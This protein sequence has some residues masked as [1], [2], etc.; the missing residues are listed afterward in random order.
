MQFEVF[1]GELRLLGAAI[2]YNVWRLRPNYCA[3]FKVCRL[4]LFALQAASLSTVVTLKLH[5]KVIK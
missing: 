5:L 4:W 1:G 2:C 3:A